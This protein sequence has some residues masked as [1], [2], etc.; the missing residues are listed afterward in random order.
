MLKRYNP[1]YNPAA[2]L[3]LDD[4]PPGTLFRI[5]GRPSPL[6]RSIERRR[7]RWLCQDTAT[8]RQYLVRG[9]SPVV[10]SESQE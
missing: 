8:S 1:D 10:V 6:F 3:H 7:T 9:S 4:L 2:E 5:A